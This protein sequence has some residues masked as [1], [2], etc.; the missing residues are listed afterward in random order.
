MSD[1][2]QAGTPSDAPVGAEGSAPAPVARPAARRAWAGVLGVAL[3]ALSVAGWQWYDTRTELRALKQ[4]LAKKLA[5]S[6]TQS[7]ESRIVSQQVRES[8][9]EA[10]VK[11]GVLEAR[12]AESQNQQPT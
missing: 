9:A 4:E 3:L 1:A 12:L 2:P 8:V 11:L 7:R 6:D 10:Q 5:E